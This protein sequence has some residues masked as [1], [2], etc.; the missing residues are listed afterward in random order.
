[1]LIL[2]QKCV[3]LFNPRIVDSWG[4]VNMDYQGQKLAELLYYWIIIVFGVSR[5]VEVIE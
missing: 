1:M 3:L 5:E 2:T 4:L